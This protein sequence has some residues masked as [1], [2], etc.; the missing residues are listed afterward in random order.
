MIFATLKNVVKMVVWIALIPIFIQLFGIGFGIAYYTGLVVVWNA[1]V[2]TIRQYLLA[3]RKGVAVLFRA[4][5][6]TSIMLPFT[7]YGLYCS[8]D[9]GVD[10]ITNGF[11]PIDD[12][13]TAC[14]LHDWNSMFA[15]GMYEENAISKS[16]Y[17]KL[18]NYAD[19]QFMKSAITSWN[20]ASG[21]YLLGLEI[22]FA[23]RIISRKL[24]G[25]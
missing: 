13:D 5:V 12:L 8:P 24:F 2:T 22:G 7:M 11:D 16:T 4:M 3:G 14:E 10:G 17:V 21:V 20:H 9:Y 18:K 15:S 1:A 23:F 19:W 25:V 6:T